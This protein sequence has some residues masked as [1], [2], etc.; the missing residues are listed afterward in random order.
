MAG[1]DKFIDERRTVMALAKKE[2][3][4][5]TW[6][7]ILDNPDDAVMGQAVYEL[8]QEA[9]ESVDYP[10]TPYTDD[11]EP[12]WAAFAGKLRANLTMHP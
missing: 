3:A 5:L 6:Q 8:F 1:N 2:M 4:A 9:L 10:I 12:V 11:A 7:E